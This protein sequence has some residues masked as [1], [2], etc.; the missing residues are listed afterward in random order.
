MAS[1]KIL[2]LASRQ[3]Y[4]TFSQL[5]TDVGGLSGATSGLLFLGDQAEQAVR[6]KPASSVHCLIVS[7]LVSRFLPCVP[8][9]ASLSGL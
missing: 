1:D 5:M 9:L 8:A 3:V 2:P 4:E 7:A 6:S